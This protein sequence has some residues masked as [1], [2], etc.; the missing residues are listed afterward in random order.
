MSGHDFRV[1]EFDP[2][3][4]YRLRPTP[5]EEND[6]RLDDRGRFGEWVTHGLGCG[7]HLCNPPW[8]EAA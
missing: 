8:R 6:R 7:C 5:E 1:F 4:E 3:G 2:D